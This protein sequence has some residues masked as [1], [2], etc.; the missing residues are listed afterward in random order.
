MVVVTVGLNEL[1]ALFQPQQPCGS[2]QGLEL[3]GSHERRLR[4]AAG[5][6]DATCVC[7][8]NACICNGKPGECKAEQ[9][10][11]E[12]QMSVFRLCWVHRKRVIRQSR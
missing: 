12:K 10:S 3:L 6:R 1:S 9:K 2:V 7:Y 4:R 11:K 8:I 5:G